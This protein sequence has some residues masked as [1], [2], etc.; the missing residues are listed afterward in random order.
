MLLQWNLSPGCGHLNYIVFMVSLEE[1]CHREESLFFTAESSYLQTLC[2]I[3]P[4]ETF[5]GGWTSKFPFKVG[6]GG[7]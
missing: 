2:A 7:V 5:F 4:K 3:L 1:R 6:V